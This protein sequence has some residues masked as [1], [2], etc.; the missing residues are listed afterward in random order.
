MPFNLIFKQAKLLL[1]NYWV[2]SKWILLT[3]CNS[4]SKI[5]SESTGI[6]QW[7]LNYF[8]FLV[9]Y[10][11]SKFIYHRVRKRQRQYF[12]SNII[13]IFT[14]IG[15]L[16]FETPQ[17]TSPRRKLP[18]LQPV[19]HSKWKAWTSLLTDLRPRISFYLAKIKEDDT[20]LY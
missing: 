5:L 13:Y 11:T 9:P 1:S 2:A 18:P 10:I 8:S 7:S 14:D 4:R 20:Y 19:N 6:R 15:V 17:L 16:N 12:Y 3:Y